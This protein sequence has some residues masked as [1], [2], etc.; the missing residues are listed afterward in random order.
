MA[1]AALALQSALGVFLIPALAW[2]ISEDRRA[3]GGTKLIRVI[4]VGLAI[5]FGLA[6]L[7]LHMPWTRTL[8]ETVA[9]GVRA[10]QAASD[11]GTRLVFGYLA[12][13]PAPFE[14]RT[15]EAG[16]ILAFRVL[17]LILVMSALTR[18]L[19]HWGILQ[20]VV[21]AAAIALQRTLGTGGPLAVSAAGSIFL[22][23]IEAPLLIRPY[24]KEMSRGALFA[25][26]TVA[27]ATVAGTV[28]AIYASILATVVPGAP[29]H[30]IAASVINV[31]GALVLARLAVPTG[32]AD[33][34]ASASVTLEGAPRSSMDAIAQGT[35]DGIRMVA[36]VAG[37]LIVMIA[38]VALVNMM[39]GSLG[40]LIGV[41]LSLE[42]ILGLICV[43]LA[44]I[45]GI[46]AP[47][48]ATAA[49]LI[50][51]KIVLNEFLAYLELLKLPPDALSPRS[52]LIVTYALCGFANLGS[53]GILIGGMTIL[54]PERRGEVANLAPKA[55]VVGVLATL[56]SAAVVGVTVWR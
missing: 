42:R 12:G 50:G 48:A 1:G 6:I 29:G 10:L 16:F 24:L 56:L 2:A 17:P 31:P 30:L 52:E 3:L 54:A 18:L 27:M 22:G 37:T 8:F 19:Y 14:E 45:I 32:F 40:G 23:L 49:S 44:F 4:A 35:S 46:P 5:Q 7:F 11:A 28:L 13:A 41:D 33:G 25:A 55:L 38:L 15:P 34:P 36:A 9:A 51:Q 21:Q 47:E 53:L 20:R 43:P 26:M 39:L